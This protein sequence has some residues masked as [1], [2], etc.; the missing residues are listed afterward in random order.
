VVN[1]TTIAAT[2]PAHAAGTVNV[3]VTNPDGQSGTLNSAYTYTSAST[4]IAFVQAKAATPQSPVSTVSVTYP[5]SQTAGNLNVVAVG[6]NDSTSSVTAISDSRGNAYT[7]AVGPTTGTSLRQSIYYAKNILGGSNTVTV[8]FNQAAPFVDVRVLEYSG[9]STSAPLDVTAAAS[10]SG[11]TASSGSATTSSA[12]ELIFGAAMTGGVIK[13]AGSGFTSRIITPDGD[14]GED[15][16]VSATGSY[17]AT[18]PVTAYAGST[19]W[20]MQMATFKAG[21]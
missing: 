12:S 10:G 9:L 6:W 15:K 18:A 16:L 2:S 19:T 1:S 20:V 21:P 3:V 5:L 8:S 7:L 4:G 14:I 11:S 13:S 17:T